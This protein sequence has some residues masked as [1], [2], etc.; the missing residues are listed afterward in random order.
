MSTSDDVSLA[1][2]L[3]IDCLTFAYGARLVPRF[4]LSIQVTCHPSEYYIQQI[5]I[6][7]NR[8]HIFKWPIVSKIASFGWNHRRFVSGYSHALFKVEN[9]SSKGGGEGCYS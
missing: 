3:F 4:F 5:V 1:N 9:E 6:K 8:M 7:V 2:V